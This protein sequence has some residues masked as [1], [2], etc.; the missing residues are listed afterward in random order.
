MKLVHLFHQFHNFWP[1]FEENSSVFQDKLSLRKNPKTLSGDICF[2]GT[3]VKLMTC[4]AG[5]EG[6]VF[7]SRGR[8]GSVAH[9][10]LKETE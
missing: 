1:F 6:G 8:E 3:I 9:L 2:N 10:E 7:S 5:I 4:S